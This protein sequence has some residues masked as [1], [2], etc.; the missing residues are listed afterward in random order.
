[1]FGVCVPLEAFS[2]RFPPHEKMHNA[3]MTSGS[4]SVFFIL[5]SNYS[6][7]KYTI[8]MMKKIRFDNQWSTPQAGECGRRKRHMH[9]FRYRLETMPAFSGGQTLDSLQIWHLHRP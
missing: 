6:I 5:G 8:N 1:M 3:E 9:R 4:N 2:S 7:R